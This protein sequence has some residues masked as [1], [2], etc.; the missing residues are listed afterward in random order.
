MPSHEHLAV[1]QLLLLQK[2]FCSSSTA[3]GAGFSFVGTGKKIN[4][5]VDTIHF[6]SD[7]RDPVE[8]DMPDTKWMPADELAMH[9]HVVQ[10]LLEASIRLQPGTYRKHTSE[11]LSDW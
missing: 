4:H 5:L 7:P 11:G 8:E 2:H 3:C 1:T 10:H 6:V 9:V